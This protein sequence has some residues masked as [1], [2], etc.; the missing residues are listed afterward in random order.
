MK[1]KI[2]L[3]VLALGFA[4]QTVTAQQAD[5]QIRGS[6]GYIPTPKYSKGSYIEV[7]NPE[8]EVAII[9]PKCEAEFG[10]DAF[11]KEILKSLLLNKFEDENVIIKDKG[12][13]R[14]SRKKKVIA[15]NNNFFKELASILTQEQID[16]YKIMDFT[17][18]KE[19]RKEKKRKRK[20]KKNKS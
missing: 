15:L 6:R 18:T 13:N 3:S 11:Q 2:L 19:E 10:L 9:I 12:N 8:K 4:L 20:D 7:R 14:E 5:R 17:E 16:Q 1:I